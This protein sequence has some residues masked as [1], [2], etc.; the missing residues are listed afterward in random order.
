MNRLALIVLI[1]TWS[2]AAAAAAPARAG[3]SHLQVADDTVEVDTSALS[4]DSLYALRTPDA[5]LLDDPFVRTTGKDGLDHLYDLEFEAARALFNQ[6]DERYPNHPIGPFLKG[7]NLWW[8]ILLDLPDTSHDEAFYRQMNEVIDR[9]NALLDENPDHFDAAF[10]KGAALGCARRTTA[11]APSGTCETSP[12]GLRTTTTTCSAK[13]CT[14]TT[15]RSSPR[16]IPSPN[17]SCG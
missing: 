5:S 16:S 9:C 17:R 10:F 4:P 14:T 12:N 13:G 3:G 2:V 1:A 6:I 7:L 11:S 8:K 15:P